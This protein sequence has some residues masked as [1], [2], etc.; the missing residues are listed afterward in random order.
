LHHRALK[1][2]NAGCTTTI[3]EA[4][5]Q[6][7]VGR[8][9]PAAI[10]RSL[11]RPPALPRRSTLIQCISGPPPRLAAPPAAAAA[12]YEEARHLLVLDQVHALPAHAAAAI[13][14]YVRS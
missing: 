10:S 8:L 5:S 9:H 7:L 6:L 3:T 12:R 11:I 1:H 14:P 13:A 2:V 4:S